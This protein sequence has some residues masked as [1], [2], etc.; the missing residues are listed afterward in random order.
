MNFT[1]A[2]F[3]F[4]IIILFIHRST[5]KYQSCHMYG[6]EENCEILSRNYC[7][8][9]TNNAGTSKCTKKCQLHSRMNCPAEFCYVS[10]DTCIERP[11]N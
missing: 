3:S 5:E 10:H 7:M 6:Q 11:G 2:F 9:R 8:W 4:F 1:I